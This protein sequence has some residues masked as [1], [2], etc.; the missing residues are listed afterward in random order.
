L[1]KRAAGGAKPRGVASATCRLQA[2]VCH[3]PQFLAWM[4][5]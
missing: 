1:F 4:M 2:G 3:R 5:H